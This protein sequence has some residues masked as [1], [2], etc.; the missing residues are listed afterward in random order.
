MMKS[1]RAVQAVLTKNQIVQ[2]KGLGLS[3]LLSRYP[4][5][6]IVSDDETV[7]A[8]ANSISTIR[9]STVN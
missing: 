9:K 1:K 3:N 2:L 6:L 4:S 8:I 5:S 7:K